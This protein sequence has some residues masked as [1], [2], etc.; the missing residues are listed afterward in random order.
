[1]QN[2]DLQLIE[3]AYA[4]IYEQNLEFSPE[5]IKILKNKNFTQVQD[6]NVIATWDGKW[7]V[8]KEGEGQYILWGGPQGERDITDL[9]GLPA[10]DDEPTDNIYEQVKRELKNFRITD[11]EI[12]E[13]VANHV[14]SGKERDAMEVLARYKD[15]VD[16][17][18]LEYAIN[19]LV[20]TVTH[21][22]SNDKAP[23]KENRGTTNLP[24]V[25]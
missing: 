20:W 21:D 15:K 24:D 23:D 5:E 8:S 12:V 13:L 16:F 10:Y 18:A 19:Y 6:N 1:M 25:G 2:K 9:E 7:Q 4:S 3:E 17:R 11:P 14:S 22:I